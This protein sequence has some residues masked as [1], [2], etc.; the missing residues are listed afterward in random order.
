MRRFVEVATAVAAFMAVIAPA[1][2]AGVPDPA[3]STV[4]AQIVGSG[5][6]EKGITHSVA[7]EFLVTVKDN[8]GTALAGV[9]V[10]ANYG[11]STTAKLLTVQPAPTTVNCPSKLISQIT[12][13]SGQVK[14]HVQ[15]A[16]FDLAN[17]IQIRANGVLLRS[18][19]GKSTDIS[20]NGVTDGV[21]L[22][23]FSQAFL[24][25]AEGDQLKADFNGD[26]NI[27]LDGVDLAI[28]GDD[29]VP[30]QGARAI[31]P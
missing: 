27:I 25:P 20:G 23:I 3:Q 1:A 21:D 8:G 5:K 18:I 10:T 26:G 17:N 16:G 30:L 12:N 6:G 13:G 22:A 19:Q 15:S 24:A 2:F 7:P 14:F 4:P 31:C 9:N 29:F 28:F 11:A